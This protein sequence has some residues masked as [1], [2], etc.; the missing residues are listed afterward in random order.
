MHLQRLKKL[1][2]KNENQESWIIEVL[3]FG[4]MMGKD[5]FKK[6]L[7]PFQNLEAY[8]DDPSIHEDLGDEGTAFAVNI[9]KGECAT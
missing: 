8:K 7:T 5:Y 6:E 3:L 9:G 1:L 2:K 4:H